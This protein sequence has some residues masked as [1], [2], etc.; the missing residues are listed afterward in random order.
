MDGVSLILTCEADKTKQT[1][2]NSSWDINL[3]V[4]LRRYKKKAEPGLYYIFRQ[5][6]SIFG[7]HVGLTVV[8]IRKE[9]VTWRTVLPVHAHEGIAPVWSLFLTHRGCLCLA[10]WVRNEYSCIAIWGYATVLTSYYPY[11]LILSLY[12]T[13]IWINAYKFKT[14]CNAIYDF[15]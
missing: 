9:R 1:K 7:A 6:Q 13:D 3:S 2:Q 11:I 4:H 12:K 14:P 15:Q 10:I 8:T 5:S